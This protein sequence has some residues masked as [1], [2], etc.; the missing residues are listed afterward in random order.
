MS[1]AEPAPHAAIETIL[2]RAPVIAVYSPASVEEA[3]AAARALVRGGLPVIEVT[4]RG[5]QAMPALR[6]IVERVD[7]AVVGA[8]TVLT[9]AQLAE[10]RDVGA[11]FAVSPGATPD[12]LAAGR[13]LAFPYL[14]AV[15]TGSELMAGLA[16]GYRCFKLFPAEAI[17]GA[18]LLRSFAGPFP[19]ARFCPTGGIGARTAPDYL[20]LPN[21]LCLGGSWLTPK[22]ALAAGD[23]SRIEALAREAAALR[24]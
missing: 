8:G 24:A 6:A 12:L 4:L 3:V 10:V 17:G 11:A 16:A 19:Q 2:R 20:A 9:P 18:A 14:P 22:D 21:V 23:W 7:G 5:P 13:D 1:A 15:A